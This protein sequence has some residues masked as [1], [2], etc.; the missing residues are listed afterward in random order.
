MVD[1]V[2]KVFR[3]GV[4]KGICLNCRKEAKVKRLKTAGDAGGYLCSSCWAKEM[5]FRNRINKTLGKG[6]KK[7]PI[8]KFS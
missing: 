6:A 4:H 3:T 5:A 1:K 8:S 7:F 2:H